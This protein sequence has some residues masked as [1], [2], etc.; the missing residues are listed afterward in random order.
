VTSE[1]VIK[2]AQMGIAVLISKSGITN[3]ALE[4]ARDL[5][6]TII[7]RARQTRF[8]IYHGRDNVV[9]GQLPS[10]NDSVG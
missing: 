9:L 8:L 2:A 10:I 5:R 4:L 7:G 3:M 1:I 6:V